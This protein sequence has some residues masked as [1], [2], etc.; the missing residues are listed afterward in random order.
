MSP[1]LRSPTSSTKRSWEAVPL[2]PARLEAEPH[3]T[4]LAGR[5]A[6]SSLGY[7]LSVPDPRIVAIPLSSVLLMR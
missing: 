5:I 1:G 2:D 3:L 7:F 4:D 6:E